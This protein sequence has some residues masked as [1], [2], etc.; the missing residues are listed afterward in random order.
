MHSRSVLCMTGHYN[1]YYV[2]MYVYV[3]G[4]SGFVNDVMFSHNEEIQT[5]AWSLRHS[6]LFIVSRQMAPIN[7]T[8]G[9]EVCYPRLPCSNKCTNT[10]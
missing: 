5:Q 9:D 10:N 4:T 6:E 3:P 1:F 2:C 7:C 8:T